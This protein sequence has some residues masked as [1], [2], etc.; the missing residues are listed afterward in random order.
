MFAVKQMYPQIFYA[1]SD[2]VV[3]VLDKPKYVS[4]PDTGTTTD[5]IQETSGDGRRFGEYI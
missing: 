5:R 3:F 2:V 4:H 1:F